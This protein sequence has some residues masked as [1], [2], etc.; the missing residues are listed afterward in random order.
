MVAALSVFLILHLAALG[1]ILLRLL[2]GARIDPDRV[3]M[4]SPFGIPIEWTQLYGSLAFAAVI[5]TPAAAFIVGAIFRDRAGLVASTLWAA[6]CGILCL[7]AVFVSSSGN[8]GGYVWHPEEPDAF[9]AWFF[10]PVVGRQLP[11]RELEQSPHP[12]NGMLGWSPLSLLFYVALVT[13][14]AV[15]GSQAGRQYMRGRR[16]S[17]SI[18]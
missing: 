4:A 10:G 14:V 15:W 3:E 18:A 13:A 6:A 5:V 12:P 17:G 1:L 16:R 8:H 9:L 2:H 11:P 7:Y